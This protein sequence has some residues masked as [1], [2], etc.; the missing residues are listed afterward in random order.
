MHTHDWP[1]APV[2]FADMGGSCKTVFTIHNMNYGVDLI[3]RAM[4]AA[5]ACTTVS[6]TYAQEVGLTHMACLLSG[7]QFC[8]MWSRHTRKHGAAYS[9]P[10]FCVHDVGI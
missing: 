5:A 1:T 10:C 2:A 9:D 3:G 7:H 6:P 4:A 8:A